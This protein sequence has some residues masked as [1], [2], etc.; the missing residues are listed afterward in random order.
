MK[1]GALTS[2]G[3][4]LIGPLSGQFSEV[5]TLSGGNTLVFPADA[6]SSILRAMA[7]YRCRFDENTKLLVVEGAHAVG[8]TKFAKELAEE[9][10]MLYMP[11]VTMDML[12]KSPY[13]HADLR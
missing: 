1:I 6:P 9:L 4:Y 13:G 2:S 5:T 12:Y 10:E 11:T 3:T 8:K 7:N